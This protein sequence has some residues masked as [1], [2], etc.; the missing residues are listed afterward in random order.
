MRIRRIKSCP[1]KNIAR[2]G[3]FIV[4]LRSIF[5][6]IRNKVICLKIYRNA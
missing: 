6:K 1:A 2:F 4:T 3:I 5:K